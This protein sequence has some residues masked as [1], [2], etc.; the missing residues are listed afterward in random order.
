MKE[1]NLDDSLKLIAKSSLVVFIG[2]FLSKLFMYFYR[3][4]I[5]RYF[6]P[7]VYGLYS[8]AVMIVSWFVIFSVLGLNS[9]ILRYIPFY[10]GKK[11]NDK[12]KFLFRYILLFLAITSI[13]FGI[14]VKF[15]LKFFI[16]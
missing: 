6:G 4:I 9:G 8:L 1:T 7:E 16:Y 3:I 15:Q 13:F 11:E 14:I 10:R 2:L 12:I 5:A